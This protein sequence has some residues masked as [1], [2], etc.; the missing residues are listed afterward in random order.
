MILHIMR[1]YLEARNI[2][3]LLVDPTFLQDFYSLCEFGLT[4]IFKISGE[5][6]EVCI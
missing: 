5:R 6:T 4:L 1:D 2:W 3:N